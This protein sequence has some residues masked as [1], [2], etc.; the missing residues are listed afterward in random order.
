[1]IL[2]PLDS[3]LPIGTEAT[4]GETTV[5]L[6][7]GMRTAALP[8]I[9]LTLPPKGDSDTNVGVEPLFSEDVGEF[10]E[11]PGLPIRTLIFDAITAVTVGTPVSVVLCKLAAKVEEAPKP[12]N[13]AVT[14]FS[15]TKIGA[16][17]P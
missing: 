5:E 12:V 7:D 14:L 8:D 15:T 11:A 10:I 13:T 9:S 16:S 4:A 6:E 3:K 2:A 17:D 1:M